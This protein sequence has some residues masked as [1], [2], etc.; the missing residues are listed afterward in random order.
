MRVSGDTQQ[1]REF[2]HFQ[3]EFSKGNSEGLYDWLKANINFVKGTT[4][5]FMQEVKD[6]GEIHLYN[7]LF[8]VNSMVDKYNREICE[9]LDLYTAV[10][11]SLKRNKNNVADMPGFDKALGKMRVVNK[12]EN[13]SIDDL[14][15]LSIG[16]K[17][18]LT[19]NLDKVGKQVGL[20]NGQNSVVE[21]FFYGTSPETGLLDRN[22][23]EFVIVSCDHLNR[24]E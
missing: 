17:S 13:E 11:P 10:I 18:K 19:S 24:G 6:K 8:P 16:A 20:C 2:R 21:Y 14:L 15:H 12:K 3:T 7:F 9:Y 23:I 5:E 1:A 22:N 4:K